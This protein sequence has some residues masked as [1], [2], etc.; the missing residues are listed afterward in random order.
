MED[1]TRELFSKLKDM[2]PRDTVWAV[3]K[4]NLFK[5]YTERCGDSSWTYFGHWEK[6]YKDISYFVII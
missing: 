5:T 6:P 3:V 2:K 4:E 1:N